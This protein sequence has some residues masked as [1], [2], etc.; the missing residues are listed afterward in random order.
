MTD[1]T[2]AILRQILG[3]L[4]V[5]NSIAMTLMSFDDRLM[6]DTRH[7]QVQENAS[8]REEHKP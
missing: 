8:I 1:D 3:E 7:L 2:N 5:A 6:S 4:K